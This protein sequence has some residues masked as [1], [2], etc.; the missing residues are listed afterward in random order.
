MLALLLTAGCSAVKTP[1]VKEERKISPTVEYI[2]KIPPAKLL[3]IPAPVENIDVEKAKQ[4]DIAQW[5]LQNEERMRRL[6]NMLIEI[7]NFFKNEEDNANKIKNE[8]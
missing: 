3:E 4:S 1:T 2:V 7:S 8:L 5:I 6:E